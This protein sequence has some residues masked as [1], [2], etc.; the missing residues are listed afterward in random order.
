MSM[1]FEFRGSDLTAKIVPSRHLSFWLV[2]LLAGAMTFISLVCL[3]IA[4]SANRVLDDWGSELDGQATVRISAPADQTDL[5]TAAALSVL[6]TT[7]GILVAEEVE[8]ASQLML[9]E[10]WLGDGVEMTNIDLPR[11]IAVKE[12]EIGP[13][14]EG[15]KLRLAGEAPGA[16]YSRHNDWR[17]PIRESANTITRIG[18]LAVLSIVLAIVVVV[19]LAAHA[20]IRINASDISVLRL[21]GAKDRFISKV[22]V[23]QIT[24]VAF[25]GSTIGL[26]AGIVL[27]LLPI[28]GLGMF[29]G[30]QPGLFQI[31]GI[32]LL[33]VV[34]CALTYLA[35]RTTALRTLKKMA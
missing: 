28:K 5:Q 34:V 18:W 22:Y 6:Q 24:I 20:A 4:F 16:T 31:L 29:S 1:L 19:V 9:L 23:R 21:I 10:P 14:L 30:F 35:A 27:V 2:A 17:E 25:V 15:L 33:P 8:R 13:D 26:L 7:P 11:L 32:F 12:D 3:V